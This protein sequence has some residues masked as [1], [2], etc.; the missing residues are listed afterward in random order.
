MSLMKE[1]SN[2]LNAYKRVY[3]TEAV[4]EGEPFKK[5][6]MNMARSKTGT[7][8]AASE[9]PMSSA[10]DSESTEEIV[11]KAN[12][13]VNTINQA[14]DAGDMEGKDWDLE[15]VLQYAP[16]EANIAAAENT[17]LPEFGFKDL[18]PL[19]ARSYNTKEPLLIY[20]DPGIGK[21][22][23]VEYFAKHIAAPSRGRI[24]KDWRDCSIAEKTEIIENPE[25]YFVLIV[26]LVNKLEPGDLMGIPKISSDKPYLETQQLK[27]IYLMSLPESDG[28]LFLDE[29]NL[30]SPQI[31]Q[32]LYEVVLGKS[33][34]GT[35]F[36]DNFAIMAAGNIAGEF[37]SNVEELPRALVDR[38][39]A[40]KL[41]AK[42]EEW[43][44]YAEN[45]GVDRRIIA[46]IK[47]DM[48]SN[49]YSRP[50]GA[51]DPFPTPRSLVK[52]SGK[53]K[54]IYREHGE[55]L[56]KGVRPPMPIY[57]EIGLEAAAKVGVA[58][59]NKFVTFLKHIRAF[60]LKQLVDDLD[61]I[62]AKEQSELMAL[63]LYLINKVRIATDREYK[64]NPPTKNG[65]PY[66]LKHPESYEVLDAFAKILNKLHPDPA[67]TLWTYIK[68]DLNI[69]QQG[70]LLEFVFHG[71]Y[72]QKI[73]DSILKKIP[74]LTKIA[75]GEV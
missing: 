22:S 23:T 25:K 41:V 6:V 62:N 38:F 5:N 9:Q 11:S 7:P 54:A 4:G 36:S 17:D 72:D 24:F 68:R 60:D 14:D 56:K 13:M 43:L 55:Y 75:K 65:G 32:S 34:S 52:L 58:W 50:T 21:T 31:L 26:E 53:M 35:R 20:G 49:F 8:V 19:I 57:R 16:G 29:I 44:E 46:F 3:V 66:A 67:M 10:P 42:P 15:D 39:T 73:K 12:N 1:K 45:N 27:W 51:S 47:T 40:G 69:Q 74:R 70:V 2:L 37:T 64:E 28:I 63:T 61:N 33:A 48:K 59:A 18:E 71:E 30:G